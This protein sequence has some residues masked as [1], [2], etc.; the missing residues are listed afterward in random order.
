MEPG[1][2]LNLGLPV[3]PGPLER[4]QRKDMSRGQILHS[5]TE[6]QMRECKI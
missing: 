2:G 5:S 6:R 4:V 3:A 1:L